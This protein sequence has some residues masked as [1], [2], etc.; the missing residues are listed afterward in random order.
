MPICNK[1]HAFIKQILKLT[2]IC[3]NMSNHNWTRKYLRKHRFQ[4]GNNS[5]VIIS[6]EVLKGNFL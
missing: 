5:V 4:G 2:L 1:H 3:Q 6:I